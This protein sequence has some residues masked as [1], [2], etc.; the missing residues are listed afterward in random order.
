[1]TF[2]LPRSLFQERDLSMATDGGREQIAMRLWSHGWD[3]FE[4]PLPAFYAATIKNGDVVLDVGSNTGYYAL[5]AASVGRDVEVHAFEP[6]PVIVDL[7]TANLAQN[8]QGTRVRVVQQAVDNVSG[9]AEL[10]IPLAHHNLVESGASLNKSFRTAWSG[11]VMVGTTTLNEYTR[12]L[13]RIDVVKIDV[14]CH[15]H[16]VLEGARE[17][18]ARMRP[19]IFYEIMDCEDCHADC[20]AIEAIRRDADYISVRLHPG[21]AVLSKAV[22]YDEPWRNQALWPSEKLD[23]LRDVC[24]RLHYRLR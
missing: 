17:T 12:N 21:T 5:L 3:R 15:E 14:E 13:P 19:V 8:L 9:V 23:M 18:L 10:F 6:L 24:Q 2:A 4:R 11:S 7:L 20:M 16:R 1:V 22:G